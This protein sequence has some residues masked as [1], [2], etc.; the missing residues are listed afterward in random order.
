MIPSNCPNCSAR[1]ELN[2]DGTCDHCGVDVTVMANEPLAGGSTDA[3]VVSPL[4]PDEGIALIRR[5]DPAFDPAGFERRAEQAFLALGQAW[6]DR[7]REAAR[8]LMSPGLHKSWSANVQMFVD[9]HKRNVLEGMRVDSLAP[10]K[11]VHGNAFDA[12]T[13]RFTATWISYEVDERTDRVIAG[14][15]T[16]QSFTEFF[17]FQRSVDART[18]D[19]RFDWVLSR[20]QRE[21]DY[22]ASADRSMRRG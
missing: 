12:L 15:R 17:T 13:V 19:G 4:A 2:D 11:V 1:L 18:T 9:E 6:Q 21:A 7:D 3:A 5:A 20:L 8:P 10:V 16:P 14:D 22:A